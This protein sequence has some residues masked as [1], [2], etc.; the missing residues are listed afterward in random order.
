[1][2][3]SPIFNTA[4]S[5]DRAARA[6]SDRASI[7]YGARTYTVLEAAL[8]TRRLAQLLAQAGV[9]QG[10]RVALISHNSPYHL[11]LHVACARLG[12]VF[13]PISHRLVRQELESLVAFTAPRVVVAEPEI[14]EVGRF[15]T[16]DMHFVIDDD[17][18]AS[19]FKPAL[20]QGYLAL[21]AAAD[22]FDAHLII[23]DPQGLS[24]L[25]TREY[26]EGPAA[27]LFTSGTAGIPKAV[28]LTHEHLW[29]GSRNFREGFEYSNLD[30][31]LVVAP[32]THI[33]GFN[34]TT[35]DLFTH[36]GTVVVVREF[37]PGNVLAQLAEHKVS[38]MFGV[39]TMYAALVTHP[40]F[41]ETDLSAFRL[42]LMGGAVVPAPLLGRLASRG[43][44]PLNV[45]GMTETSASGCYLPF[46][47]AAEHPGAIGRPFAHVQA[48][49]VDSNGD[50]A[51]EG[52]L[53]VRGP[54]VI[55]SYWHNEAATAESFTGGWLRTGDLVR[56]DEGGQL[57]VVGRLHQLINSGGEK[58]VP[59]E[60]EA[61]LASVPGVAD[62][63][64]VGVPD[65]T[66][67]ETVAA[68]VVATPG[69]EPPTLEAMRSLETI[70]RY[71][72]PRALAIVEALPVNGNGKVDRVVAAQVFRA[73]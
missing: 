12:A 30:V 5:L 24:A 58:I 39:P 47:L 45:W 32:M 48:R 52:E 19:S 7:H 1:M 37:E 25:N 55:T 33:G 27:I 71:K 8:A 50:D 31:E 54:N 18:A 53:L 65:E 62:V 57:W 35:L 43:L 68:V 69:E 70:A 2:R 3:K 22:A 15:A 26:P 13:V 60:V 29:W 20:S 17:P 49:I 10:D 72:L 4:H 61:A 36:G 6:H 56:M 41:S 9:A 28:E 73:E 34:G 46:E 21:A 40:D 23:P 64:V 44:R 59:Q 42:P 16:P 66:W 51:V 38:I 14:A 63:V 67:G 11:L